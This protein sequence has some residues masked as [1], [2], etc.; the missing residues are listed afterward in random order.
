[1]SEQGE[2]DVGDLSAAELM[3][4]EDIDVE[5]PREKWGAVLAEMVDVLTAAALRRGLDEEQALEHA[6]QNVLVLAQHFGGRPLYLPRGESL[7]VA[8]RDRLIYHLDKGNN[9][10]ALAKRFDLTVR[11]IQII[12]ATQRAL[13]L[14]KVQGRLFEGE[15]A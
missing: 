5:L 6:Q 11:Q 13:H 14:R 10:E 3:A 15:Q 12:R 1:M 2:L 7:R 4:R 8:L 9:T